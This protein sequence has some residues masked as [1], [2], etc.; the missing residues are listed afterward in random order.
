MSIA[1]F[2]IYILTI[3]LLSLPA[4]CS[5]VISGMV[6]F[7]MAAV[8]FAFVVAVH[9]SLPAPCSCVTSGLVRFK[10]AAVV[11]AFRALTV[12]VYIA[13]SFLLLCHI[14]SDKIQD[15]R[16]HIRP[17]RHPPHRCLCSCIRHRT[18][19]SSS[20]RLPLSGSSWCGSYGN[21]AGS[22]WRL[23]SREGR[24]DWWM[25]SFRRNSVLQNTITTL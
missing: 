21:S 18:F 2:F 6:G 3:Y 15:G 11:F 7:K 9:M 13:T 5:W 10:M 16:R 8:V 22:K 17:Q 25:N 23:A 4:P 12:V 1:V 14:Q 20:P 19:S 24:S